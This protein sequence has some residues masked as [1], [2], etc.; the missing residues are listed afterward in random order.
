MP[1]L[2]WRLT[3]PYGMQFVREVFF[4]FNRNSAENEALASVPQSTANEITLRA[5]VEVHKRLSSY[6]E[7]H[8]VALVHDNIAVM[9]RK[10]DAENIGKMMEREMRGAAYTAGFF[11]VPFV[12]SA[13]YGNS[14]DH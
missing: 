4:V 6:P 2:R 1:E 8:I 12:A 11:R 14:L 5:A 3:T 7:A 9:C 10:E 13:E